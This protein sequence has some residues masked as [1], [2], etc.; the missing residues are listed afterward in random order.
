MNREAGL[1]EVI[2]RITRYIADNGIAQRLIDK[3]TK[4]VLTKNKSY[5]LSNE[6]ASRIYRNVDF[7]TEGELNNKHDVEISWSDHAEYR[8]DLRGLPPQKVNKFVINELN[9]KY[10]QDDLIGQERVQGPGGTV[11]LDYNLMK[12][13]ASVK[14]ITVWAKIANKIAKDEMRKYHGKKLSKS[15]DR[16]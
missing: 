4:Y 5:D 9:K 13:P 2:N 1:Q 3:V 11:V 12:D 6:E 8:S 16:A 7:S 10:K 14:I 15:R